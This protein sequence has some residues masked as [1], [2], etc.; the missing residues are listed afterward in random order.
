MRF[1][2][3]AVFQERHLPLILWIVFFCYAVCMALI[4]QNVI[5]PN[6]GGGHGSGKLLA[7]DAVHFDTVAWELALK[8]R[9]YGWGVWHLYIDYSAPG[10]VSILAVLY[11]VFGHDPSVIIPI[12][13]GLHAFG[14][15]LIFHLARTLANSRLVGIYTGII[16]GTF[17]VIYPSSLSWYGQLHK[18]S[19]AIAG[20]LLMLVIWLEVTI[21]SNDYKRGV[22]LVLGGV[23]S[24]VLIGI[25]RPYNL[26]MLFVVSAGALIIILLI[27]LLKKRYYD[28]LNKSLVGICLMAVIFVGVI[29]TKEHAGQLGRTVD[30]TSF[31]GGSIS[32]PNRYWEWHNTEWIP[33]R[34]EKYIATAARTRI[35]VINNDV[36]EGA[37]STMD[38]YKAPENVTEVLLYLPRAFQIAALAPFPSMW[39]EQTS[40]IKLLATGEMAIYYLCVFG[41]FFL[42]KYN[43]TPK[44]FVAIYF[45]VAFLT[46]LGFTMANLG[47]LYRLRYAYFFIL[48]T[49]GVLG[50]MTLL[51]EKGILSTLSEIIIGKKD[52]LAEGE[53]TSN[54]R[55]ERKQALGSIVYVMSLTLIGFVGFFLRDILMAHQFGLGSELDSFFVALMVIMTIVTIFCLPLGTSF[56]PL[57]LSESKN[58]STLCM[59]GLISGISGI[60]AVGLLLICSF[61]FLTAPYFLPLIIQG[62]NGEMVSRVHE[63]IVYSLP[64][65]FFSGSVVLGNAV[66]NAEGKVLTTSSAQIIVPVL[67]ILT[68]IVLS[69][70]YGVEIV[71]LGM[72][73]GQL[74][75]LLIVQARLQSIG[76]SLKPTFRGWKELPL[77]R[78]GTQ[79]SPL[80]IS[81]LFISITLLVSTFLAMSLPEGAVSIFNLG[82]KV[83]LL[84]TGLISVAITTVILPYF[85]SLIARD[86]LGTARRELSIFLSLIT[87]IAAPISVV[88][89]TFSEEIIGLIFA[90]GDIE[91][92]GITKIARVMQYAVIQIP[93]FACNI[94]L[95]K[96]AIATRH[97]KAI[98]WSA[99]ISLIVNIVASLFLMDVMGVAG[100]ALAGTLSIILSTVLLAM[101]L[102]K[103][104]HISLFDMAI[105]LLNWL[106]FLTLAISINFNS[107][108]GMVVTIFTYFILLLLYLGS[109]SP[110]KNE[111]DLLG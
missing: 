88:F 55:S 57:F 83:V 66:L 3:A 48:L 29:L 104:G 1:K 74:L 49:L 78:L 7:N 8:V 44:V 72:I 110:E 58:K 103:Y 18:D 2:E 76:Y 92:N 33:D 63:L 97:V 36:R 75:N 91:E 102:V 38:A 107:F 67:T 16:A 50:W 56:I 17:F 10:N 93:F 41:V 30:S 64:L 68:I 108:S 81:A 11:V 71:I 45:A 20:I 69:N 98:L 37:G 96:F 22:L 85:S 19:Y 52:K 42:L 12:N 24:C 111:L 34:I 106:L 61:L 21:K 32:D 28:L 105:L 80:V 73:T 39:L 9:E 109:I 62:D 59:Q 35:H 101:S 5:V 6:M 77:I 95:L 31:S 86:D 13:A 40:A 82:N 15:V 70:N 46:I 94:F 84:I 51:K 23:L 54:P 60:I 53:F 65:L 25:V 27:S 89:F 90:L 14:G 26:T 47:T 79:Y 99:L 43:R 100:I 4:F 87:F